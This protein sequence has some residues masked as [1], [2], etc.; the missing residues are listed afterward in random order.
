MEKL[1]TLKGRL[2]KDLKKI[3]K[4][5]ED[6]KTWLEIL[7][8]LTPIFVLMLTTFEKLNF[9][10]FYMIP[11]EYKELDIYRVLKKIVLAFIILTLY[12]NCFFLEITTSI[13]DLKNII[14]FLKRK[15]IKNK[16][17]KKIIR[18]IKS[19]S[20][21][22]SLLYVAL[23]G[24]LL[25]IFYYFILADSLT[26]FFSE[27]IQAIALKLSKEFYEKT[28]HFFII[29]N[30]VLFLFYRFS[31]KYLKKFFKLPIVILGVILFIYIFKD[32]F[33]ESEW[34]R[35]YELLIDN[36]KIEVVLS[37]KDGKLIVADG[38]ITENNGLETLIIDT[39]KYKIKNSDGLT[40]EY[41]NFSKI[42]IKSNKNDK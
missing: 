5:K 17:R 11:S 9:T 20:L 31:T 3:C 10:N 12:Y 21:F 25:G 37:K 13:K 38:E 16:N 23:I 34:K 4:N 19:F 30:S 32:I 27:K 6:L 39:K 8:L 35:S 15:S 36:E 26:H 14:L 29:L 2:K 7:L 40:L 1:K 22:F 41:R 42:E 18:G 33:N 24:V 28:F